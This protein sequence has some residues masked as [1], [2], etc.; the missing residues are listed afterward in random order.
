MAFLY[1]LF[2]YL[3][4]IVVLTCNRRCHKN[5]ISIIFL[6]CLFHNFKLAETYFCYFFFFLIIFSKNITC[7]QVSLTLKINKQT[8]FFLKFFLM[9]YHLK[10]T[11]HILFYL[12]Y[13]QKEP[14][15]SYFHLHFR[16][17]KT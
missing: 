2:L 5:D 3:T 1:Y 11:N 13:P 10:I 15:L 16:H 8:S 9:F 4:C 6:Y 17:L 12:F 7:L 14:Y